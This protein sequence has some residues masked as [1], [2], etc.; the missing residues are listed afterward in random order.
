MGFAL[1]DQGYVGFGSKTGAASFYKD[2]YKYD[3][4]SN[5]WSNVVE[6]PGIGRSHTAVFTIGNSAF[7]GFG[8]ETSEG[9]GLD[10]F[11]E[12]ISE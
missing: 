4:K 7:T 3:D 11:Y 12:F 5:S 8:L 2:V 6:F 10:D 9:A 1:N